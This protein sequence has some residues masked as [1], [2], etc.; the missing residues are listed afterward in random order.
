MQA[1]TE[2][3]WGRVQCSLQD[4]TCSKAQL[5]LLV[6]GSLAASESRAHIDFVLVRGVGVPGVGLA[7]K[8]DALV[9]RQHCR[10]KDARREGSARV[11]TM[12]Q[13]DLS[14]LIE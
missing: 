3:G 14:G 13:E 2:A 1:G 5:V 11:I 6:A 9:V 10:D 7:I 12:V 8:P 4:G